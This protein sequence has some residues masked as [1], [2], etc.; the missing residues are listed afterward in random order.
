MEIV[1]L[2]LLTDRLADMKS[3]YT[4]Q[5]SLPLREETA[6]SFAVDMGSTRL[7][8]SAAADGSKPFYHFA[9]NIPENKIEEAR[10][11]LSRRTELR[12]EDGE[13]LV[14]FIHWNAHSVYFHD[15][16]GNIVELI[17]RHNLPNG[18]D[19]PFDQRDFLC[20]SEIGLPV[21]DVLTTM[22]DL[23][24][25]TGIPRWREPSSSFATLGDEHG[26][27]IIVSLGRVWFMSD[28]PA[29]AF[30]LRVTM[31][32]NER[33]ELQVKTYTLR[34]ETNFQHLR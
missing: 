32:G 19:H 7:H 4:E 13:E 26:L 21:D 22:E 23:Q 31:K 8:F 24:L 11:W 10:E 27:L 16:A 28:K 6:S 18:V 17:A 25:T 30:P 20:V 12:R 3:F 14:H 15:P 2:E 33:K 29:E 9:I 5:L 34:F 1:R